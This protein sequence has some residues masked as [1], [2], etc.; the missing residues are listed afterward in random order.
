[1]N[2]RVR[3]FVFNYLLR[4]PLLVAGS[5]V[6]LLYWSLYGWWGEKRY[7]ARAQRMLTE[8]IVAEFS[9]LFDEHNAKVIPIEETNSRILAGWSFV[10]LSVEGL[11]LRFVPWRDTRQVHVASENMPGQW[12]DLSEVLDVID[13]EN[14]HDHSIVA[15]RD[16]ARILRRDW[17]LVKAALSSERYPAVRKQLEQG[18]RVAMASA[19]MMENEI[20]R[21]LYPDK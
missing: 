11:L 12:Q 5:V 17:L 10:T 16:A 13:P 2:R 8:E 4:P 7:L 1:M 6:R 20:N 18:H 3:A 19:K 15:F 21:R 14:S 9:F